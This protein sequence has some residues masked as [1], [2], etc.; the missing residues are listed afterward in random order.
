MGEA[1]WRAT[2]RRY[3]EGKDTSIRPIRLDSRDLLLE[4][5]EVA[6]LDLEEAKR[7]LDS[8]LHRAEIEKEVEDMHN[9]GINSIPVMIFEVEGVT[10]GSWLR[11][12][13]VPDR[14]DTQDPSL[15]SHQDFS[16]TREI[17]HGSGS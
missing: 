13:R 10:K 1:M 17:N 7:V 2:S 12:P 9:A 8:D 4:C 11:D 3:F 6:G 5:A 14:G 16:R 15:T